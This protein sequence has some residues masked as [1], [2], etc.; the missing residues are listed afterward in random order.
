MN[1]A[2]TTTRLPEAEAIETL[3]SRSAFYRALSV[4][5]HHPDADTA[6]WLAAQEHHRMPEFV[7]RVGRNR[8]GLVQA[9]ERLVLELDSVAV[10]AWARQYEQVFGH[11]VRGTAPAYELEYGEEHEY[12]QP[13]SL[14]DISAFYQAFGLRVS[15]KVRERADHIV[16]ECEFLQ[17]A[18]YKQA[19][20]LDEGREEEAQTCEAAVRRFLADH[21]GRWGPAFSL[22]LSR[23]AGPGIFRRIADA[24]LAWLVEECARMQVPAGSM[25]FPLR[26]PKEGDGM[27]CA[28]CPF[29]SREDADA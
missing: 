2:V 25:E 4:L 8:A 27:D 9:V 1:D 22:R 19:C 26:L 5:L 23:A 10:E 29:A 15:S 18:L 11:S 13:Q 17:V 24:A 12:R 6:K 7:G 21:L 3:L 14:S 16:T 20:A 28:A